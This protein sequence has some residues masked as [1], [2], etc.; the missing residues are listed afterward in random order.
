MRRLDVESRSIVFVAIGLAVVVGSL[1]LG[2]SMHG[3]RLGILLQVSEFI[4]IG[5]AGLGMVFVAERPSVVK[6]MFLRSFELLRPSRYSR[7]AYV[8]LLRVL[9]ALLYVARREGLLGIES[10]VEAPESS[11]IFQ[12]YPSFSENRHAVRFLCDTL[13]VL[14]TGAVE[15]HHLSEI[16]DLDLERHHEERNAVPEAMQN[17]AD[18][19]PAFGIVAAVLGVIITMGKI[20]G[21]PEAVGRSVAAALVGT[22]LGIFL[23][24]GLF[25]PLSRAMAAR[26]REEEQYLG[27]IRTA[28]LS[29]ARGDRPITSVEFARRNIDP[30]SRPTF[31]DLEGFARRRTADAEEELND[32]A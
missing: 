23:G 20:G 14:L 3:G 15:D 24:Y 7:E 29:F 25:G 27:C 18:A 8:D 1:V 28:L 2:F 30:E 17:V 19:M 31:A 13:K 5:G 4:I 21:A 6:D 32:A 26:V 10:H 16:L 22:F 9:Y 12:R 11:E